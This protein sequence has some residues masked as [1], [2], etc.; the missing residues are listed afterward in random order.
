LKRT[1]V[2]GQTRNSPVPAALE[3]EQRSVVPNLLEVADV[4]ENVL[5]RRQMSL[6]Q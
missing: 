5:L 6:Q 1:A 4:N 3:S 2:V